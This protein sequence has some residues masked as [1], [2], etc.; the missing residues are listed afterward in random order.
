[1]RPRCHAK[2]VAPTELHPAEQCFHCGALNWPVRI[3]VPREHESRQ[4]LGRDPTR[5]ALGEMT[6]HV[7]SLSIVDAGGPFHAASS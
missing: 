5:I 4:E 2:V 6:K 3:L 1:L 7:Q